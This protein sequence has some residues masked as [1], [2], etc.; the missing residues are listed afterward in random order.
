MP[1]F[2][3]CRLRWFLLAVLFG[4]AVCHAEPSKYTVSIDAPGA[5][6]TL[7]QDNLDIVKWQGNAFVD[8][9]QLARLLTAAP[10]DI[11]KLL[12]TQGYFN[13]KVVVKR[14]GDALTFHVEPGE[15]AMISD[16]TLALEGPIRNEPD[17][18][19][20]YA[21]LLEV[22]PLPIGD[23]FS[24][25]AWDNAKR[26]GLQS[27][28]LDRFPAAT[29]DSSEALVDP[30]KNEAALSVVYQSGPRVTLGA[31]QIFGLKKYPQ[32][33]V[34]RLAPFKPGDPYSQAKLLDFQSQLQNT[35]YF[36]NVFIDVPIDPQAPDEVPVRVELTEAPTQKVGVGGGYSTDKGARATLDYRHSNV[37]DLGWIGTAKLD[38]EQLDPSLALGLQLPPDDGG[39]VQSLGYTFKRTDIEGQR[40][41]LHTLTAQRT[42][43]RAGI[44][45]TQALQFQQERVRASDQEQSRHALMPSQSWL[46]RDL[47]DLVY[48]RQGTILQWQ[49]G[50]AVRGLLS[51]TSFVRA[52]GRGVL[53][54]PLGSKGLLLARGEAGQVVTENRKDV[55][56]ELL[57]RAGGS[58]SVRGY[59]FQSLGLRNGDTVTGGRV[60]ATASAEYQH[61]LFGNW[62]AAV[63]TDAG[64]AADQWQ[65]FRAYRGYGVG[66]RWASPVGPLAVDVAYGEAEKRFRLH[67]SLGVSF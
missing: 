7:L 59:D 50:G 27:V 5:L 22:W 10:D 2:F 32:R 47:D 17:Y 34:E 67:F 9:E 36:S 41:L 16:V 38:L 19:Q 28:L 51:T 66:A 54:W 45:V 46:R 33:I 23:H 44:E 53:Y 24:Q 43:K 3:R 63:F 12:A 37:R 1:H 60:L 31:L 4:C 8:E 58:G 52:W 48:P 18:R 15:L 29:V 13:P 26:R 39:Y 65:D 61:R 11:G 25:S 21:D 20:R 42:R 62:S 40:S 57:F 30:Q 55:P 56:S 35:P 49:L 64:G 14:V 6:S